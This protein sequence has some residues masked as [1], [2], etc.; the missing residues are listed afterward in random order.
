MSANQLPKPEAF[1]LKVW[2]SL[3]LNMSTGMFTHRFC[4]H[5]LYTCYLDEQMFYMNV[6]LEQAR[7]CVPSSTAFSVGCVLVVKPATTTTPVVLST[8]HSRE[9]PGNTHAEANALTKARALPTEALARIMSSA[10]SID[11]ILREVD[12]YTTMEPCSVRTSGLAPCADALIAARVRRC[13][14]GVGEP[15]DFVQCEGARKVREAGIEVIWVKGLEKDCLAVA[16][17]GHEHN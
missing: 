2:L 4:N 5:Q 17:Q 16:R 14:I 10:S 1:F 9:L 15:D 13:L 11:E 8:G 12:V 3:R 6:A 7:R